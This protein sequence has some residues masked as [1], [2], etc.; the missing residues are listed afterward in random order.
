[1]KKLFSLLLFLAL[2]SL[3]TDLFS[4]NRWIED[5]E[6]MFKI[7]VPQNYQTN[8]YRDGSDKVHAFVSRDNNV[9]ISIR[10]FELPE[11]ITVD[12]V[13]QAFYNKIIPGATPLVIQTHILN[14]IPGKI[15]GYKWRYNN[16]NVMLGAFYTIKNNIGYVVWSM[17]PENLFSYR[18]SESDA[19]TNSFTILNQEESS[20]NQVNTQYQSLVSDDALIEHLIPKGSTVRSSETGQSV[21]N[22]PDAKGDKK[23]TMV[24]QNIIKEGRNLNSFMNEQ[25]ASI[26]KN[27]AT[28][29]GQSFEKSGDFYVCRYSYEYNGSRFYYTAADGPVTFYLIG[30]VGGIQNSEILENLSLTV[31]SSLKKVKSNQ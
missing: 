11:N 24:I 13:I 28:L 20:K 25:I 10:S 6:M 7:S 16:I 5:K 9:A 18:S 21:W 17:I 19:I 1:M 31:A 23:L 14:G 4:Q 30:F 22:I 27:G 3:C 2:S 15:A 26:R 29:L 12:Q 8:Q